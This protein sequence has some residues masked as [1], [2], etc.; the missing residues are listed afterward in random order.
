MKIKPGVCLGGLKAEM[1]VVLDLVPIIFASKGY[2]C[3]LTCAVEP[4]PEG[5]HPKG[6]AL[7]FD[8]STYISSAVGMEI[9][10]SVKAYLGEEFGV[11]W[12]GPR[13]HLHV[14]HPKPVS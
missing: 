7:D 5:Q 11:I 6:G 13:W 12:H 2:D 10:A 4:R 1:C 8:S 14:Q 3:W 9:Q